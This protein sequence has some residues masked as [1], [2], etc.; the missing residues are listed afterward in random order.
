MPKL[1]HQQ[2]PD[3]AGVHAPSLKMLVDQL[4]YSGLIEISALCCCW[5]EQDRE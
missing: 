3:S 5:F 4:S 1:K 2:A